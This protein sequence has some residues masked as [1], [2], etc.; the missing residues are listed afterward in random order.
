MA[1][2]TAKINSAH[3]SLGLCHTFFLLGAKISQDNFAFTSNDSNISSLKKKISLN[4]RDFSMWSV[5][6]A[7]S[8]RK[9]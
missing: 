6:F 9:K 5:L 2:V 1:W 8:L 7:I 4:I 3:H